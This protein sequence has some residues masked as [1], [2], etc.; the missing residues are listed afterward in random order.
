MRQCHKLTPKQYLYRFGLV[1]C[2]IYIA[3]MSPLSP[4]LALDEKS[5]MDN[6]IYFLSKKE[7]KCT[8]GQSNSQG[9]TTIGDEVE[10]GVSIYGGTWDGKNLKRDPG[11]DNGNSLTGKLNGRTTFAELSNAKS[12][13]FKALT[14]ALKAPENMRTPANHAWKGGLKP[15]AKLKIT[16]NGKTIVM[17]KG[18]VGTGGGKVEGKVRAVDL[19]YETAKLLD[20]RVGTGVA[21]VQLVSDDTPVTPLDGQPVTT[22]QSTNIPMSVPDGSSTGERVFK[23]LLNKGLSRNQALGIVANLM[24]ESGG[25]TLDLKPDLQNHIGAYG[26]AQWLGGRR[27]G[28]QEFAK[29]NGMTEKDFVA[30]VNYLWDELNDSKKPYKSTVLDPIKASS[31]LAEAT[32]IFLERFE[33]PCLPGHCAVEIVRRMAHAAT[34]ESKL[35]SVS[36]GGGS[37]EEKCED[38][39]AGENVGANAD[40]YALPIIGHDKNP[41]HLNCTPRMSSNPCH[42]D[43][44][45]AFDLIAKPG[46]KVVAITDGVIDSTKPYTIGAAAS[47]P[48]CKSIQFKGDDGWYY[49]YGHTTIKAAKGTRFKA[50]QVMG[51]VGSVACGMGG[52]SHLHIDRGSPKGRTAGE[53]NHRDDGFVSLMHKLLGG[54]E[55]K[56]SKGTNP[57]PAL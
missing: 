41:K 37:T 36:G 22:S 48:E 44:T 23:F 26:I 14:D 20:F 57:N 8:P 51:V 40:G 24:Q 25:G 7:D 13:D 52:A 11:D 2:A 15:K 4:A 21:K 3:A 55:D 53:K 18:D 56:G 49:W 50:G 29:K 27:T 17:E 5:Y 28:L 33:V 10:V 19:W 42:H 9:Y 6:F 38:N 32:T 16:Y 45:P 30:Q 46:T 31:T 34:A 39:A 43:G 35:A 12:L 47:D 54:A 1:L